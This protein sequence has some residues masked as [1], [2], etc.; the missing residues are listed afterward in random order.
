MC[1]PAANLRVTQFGWGGE[2]APGF[3]NR[4]ANDMLRFDADVATTCFGMNDGRYAPMNPATG[5]AYR[6]GQLSIVRQLKES[7]VQVH[8][9]RFARL[10]RCRHVWQSQPRTSQDVQ[11]NAG[12]DA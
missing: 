5:K 2:T 7:G 10:R 11:R 4:M 8:R 3:A 12:G 1:Q 6:D 9:R